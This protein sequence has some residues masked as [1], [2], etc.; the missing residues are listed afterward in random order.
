MK[1]AEN[2]SYNFN[3]DSAFVILDNA[4]KRKPERPEAYLN[5]AKIFLWFYLGSKENIDYNSFF[6]YSDS[7][8]IQIENQLTEK[9]EDPYL[10]YQLGNN[11]KYRAMAYGSFG[12][13]LDAFWATKKSVSL[14]EDVIELDSNFYSAYGG[15]GIFEYA[16][17]YVP[18][19]FNWALALSGLSADKNNGFD[20]IQTAAQK[21]KYDRNEFKYHLSKLYDEHLADYEASLTILK[22]LKYLY[23][24]NSLFHYQ[25]AIEYIKSKK[26]KSAIKS[27]EEVLE[28]NHPKFRQTNAFAQFLLGD[29]HFITGKYLDAINYYDLFLNSTKTIDY[30]GIA[31]LRKAYC[32]HF[33]SN[34]DEFRRNALLA[35]HGNLDIEEDKIAKELSLDILADGFS[36]EL[37]TFILA[38]N[39]YLSGQN[40]YL[41]KLEIDSTNIEHLK[42]QILLYKSNILI[43]R[44]KI[45]EA[46]AVL[47]IIDTLNKTS[48]EWVEPYRHLNQ[49][50]IEYIKKNY[51]LAQ[52]QLEIAENN[53]DYYKSRQIQSM[54]NGLKRKLKKYM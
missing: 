47:A 17:S 13:T 8:I 5:K 49:A 36:K 16:L 2:L 23:P 27:L 26:L 31:S 41:M 14:Y 4:I 44:K 50:R 34:D 6:D 37:E 7:A 33:L 9:P 39:S 12:N 1:S 52:E 15:I 43:D 10:L 24:K 46:E 42:V 3:F 35:S 29:I 38:E 19:L 11:F 40:D 32:Y 30:T 20:L 53:N 28:I 18:A 22:E 21:G 48:A 25:A 51:K 54:I 45:Q